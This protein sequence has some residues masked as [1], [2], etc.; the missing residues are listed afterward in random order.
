K[1]G[2]D[3]AGESRQ[4]P[5][6]ASRPERHLAVRGARPFPCDVGERARCDDAS[7]PWRGRPSRRSPQPAAG[8][9][10]PGPALVPGPPP[11][12]PATPAPCPR[13]PPPP[14]SGRAAAAVTPRPDEVRRMRPSPANWTRVADLLDRGGRR[15]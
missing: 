2:E 11:P 1:G 7:A 13:P 12:Q 5:W 14:P 4:G 15:P 8:R 3:A 10:R 6:G 9:P